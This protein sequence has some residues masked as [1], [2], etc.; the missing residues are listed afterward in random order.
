MILTSSLATDIVEKIKQIIGYD[1]NIM[2]NMGIIIAST[3]PK[4]VNSYHKGAEE[5]I[6]TG[7]SIEITEENAKFSEGIKPGVNLPISFNDKIVG[8]VGITG[9]PVI[10]RQFG[11]VVKAMVEL[12]LHQTFLIQQI[13]MELS[14]KER[15][16]YD[17]LHENFYNTDDEQI[18]MRG[19]VLGFD[20]TIPRVCAVFE[21][22]SFKEK[23]TNNE[24]TEDKTNISAYSGQ[25]DQSLNK[26]F[27]NIIQ[28]YI[29]N[30]HDIIVTLSNN[31]FAIL[32]ALKNSKN[33]KHEVKQIIRSCENIIREIKIKSSV[34]IYAGIGSNYPSVRE[35]TKSFKEAI[36]AIQIGKV[37]NNSGIYINSQKTNVFYIDNLG[38]YLLIDSI[39]KEICNKFMEKYLG[40]NHNL[41]DLLDP[42]LKETLFKFFEC[43]LN[44]S[45][46]SR[47][48]YIHRNT[49]LYRLDKIYSL[50]NRDPRIF[51]DAID[52]TIGL[53]INVLKQ[54]N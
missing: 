54:I 37:I 17:L 7:K 4:R 21:I 28:K 16:L 35:L 41:N 32:F 36:K 14:A 48:L 51:S 1:I 31:N 10:V 38:L 44:V 47:E 52:L 50:T 3:N 23:V 53:L 2:N 27:E 15:F 29:N 42:T 40:V 46:A 20:L 8:V 43:N 26:K 49:L 45:K 5:V 19:K 39:P 13:H 30:Q 22:D 33:Y 24:K 18:I 9:E 11:E 12:M 34:E 6:K 25:F